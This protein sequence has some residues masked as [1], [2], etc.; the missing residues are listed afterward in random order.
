MSGLAVLVL[1]KSPEPGR[2]KTR[3]CPPLTPAQAAELAAAALLDSIDAARA[4]PG[5]RTVVVLTGLLERAARAAE[6]REALRGVVVVPQ[7]GDGLGARIA[8]AHRDGG[9]GLR[10]LQ[11]GMDTPQV[12]AALLGEAD[13]ALLTPGVD[14]VLGPAADGGWWALGLRRPSDARLVATVPTSRDDTGART[15]HALRQ[16]GLR[17]ALLPELSDVDTVGDA[18]AVAARAPGTRF[19]AAVRALP[20]GALRQAAGQRV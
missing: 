5:A 1:A 17:V 3:L 11:I 16:G 15:L 10:T 7:R 19:A 12:D 18:V 8:A 4:V 9:A 6:I 2:V 20:A 13:H 14:A